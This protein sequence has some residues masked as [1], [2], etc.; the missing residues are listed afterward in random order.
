MYEKDK[1]RMVEFKDWKTEDI[2]SINAPALI[3]S[4]YEDVVR[5]EYAVEMFRLIPR[6]T[7]NTSRNAR[8]IYRRS[9]H[10]NG[11]QQNP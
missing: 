3:I 1:K 7:F 4:G 9:N 2:H 10:R 5:P 6:T 8:R 11:T